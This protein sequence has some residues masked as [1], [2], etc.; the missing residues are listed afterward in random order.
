ME[1]TQNA[2]SIFNYENQQFDV[3]NIEGNPWFIGKQVCNILGYSNTKDALARH[4]DAEDKKLVDR[5]VL[6]NGVTDTVANHDH[7][8]DAVSGINTKITIINESG[9]YSLIL[10]SQ[11]PSAKKFKRWVTSEVLP[12]IRK[13]GKY[14]AP[15]AKAQPIDEKYRSIKF[16]IEGI[17]GFFDKS[18]LAHFLAYDVAYALGIVINHPNF[19]QA[20]YT[21]MAYLLGHS[22]TTAENGDLLVKE[23]ELY[24]L[25]TRSRTR[26]TKE[27]KSVLAFN[28]IPEL[29]KYTHYKPQVTT[30][31]IARVA[32]MNTAMRRNANI[33][34]TNVVKD[35]GGAAEEIVRIFGASKFEALDAA[36]SLAEQSSGLNLEPLREVLDSV[37]ATAT[38][39]AVDGDDW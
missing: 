26:A 31:E 30:T 9:L 23:P 38:I 15:K 34:V 35:V 22:L 21:K 3:L 37:E 7:S 2:V 8:N 4:V 19:I 32:P 17:S 36:I 6:T 18:G 20:N 25:V 28:V 5:S 12:S 1:N 10:K 27:F 33:T 29:K 11:M 13:T 16:N 24:T 14:E 39:E